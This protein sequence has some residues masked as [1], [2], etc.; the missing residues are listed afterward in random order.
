[1]TRL[2]KFITR[3]LSVQLS[4]MV[5]STMAILM[6][7][8]LI[9]MLHFSRKAIK[10]EALEKASQTLEGTVERIDNILLSV[11]QATGNIYYS[12]QPH[13][14]QPDKI[15]VY[16]RKLVES[17]PY[18]AGCVI[19]FKPGFYQDRENFIVY[20]HRDVSE[21]DSINKAVLTEESYGNTPYTEQAWFTEALSSG[22]P[23][24]VNSKS[25][26]D[27]A[28]EPVY[29][30]CLPI[31]GDDNQPVGVIA[32]D[33][34]LNLLS[35]IVLEMRPSPS[36][37]CTLLEDDGSLIVHPDSNKLLSQT[38]STEAIQE[39]DLNQTV[40]DAAKSMVS[41]ETGYKQFRMN[42]TDYLVFYKPFQRSAVPGRSLENQGWSVG[43]IYPEDDIFGDYNRLLY[44]V[45]AI[46]I[47]GLLLL[48][49]LSGAIIHRQLLPLRMLTKSA[50]HIAEGNYNEVIPDSRQ[51]DEIGRLQNHF[52]QMQQSLSTNIGEL[53]ELSVTL[54]KRGKELH[55]AYEQAQRAERL[56]TVFL[57][58]MT[59]QMLS[60]ADAI[61]TDVNTLCNLKEGAEPGDAKQL[62]DDIQKQG[63]TI[64]ELLK[65]LLHLSEEETGKEADHD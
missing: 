65:N 53:E 27:A 30:F 51:H 46:A 1:M 38:I 63:K 16:C 9:F 56:K 8:S 41:G 55:D 4:L 2:P 42:D 10:E 28:K 44:Y 58:N 43:I 21:G 5:V 59:D 20:V 22:K 54:D 40:S 33:V 12:M 25:K 29:A 57:H 62:A 13:L 17:N 52:Q 23:D 48:F 49:V 36:V 35:R 19:A 11:E 61:S 7:A 31:P 15:N 32:V 60:P 39:T 3:T 24:W 26:T 34:S 18:I 45:V 64:A 14:D 6:I 50:Q 47:I 37:Y